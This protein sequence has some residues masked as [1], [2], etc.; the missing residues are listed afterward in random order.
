MDDI[1]IT[2]GQSVSSYSH[3]GFQY[4]VQMYLEGPGF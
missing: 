2:S 3:F 1:I 4:I